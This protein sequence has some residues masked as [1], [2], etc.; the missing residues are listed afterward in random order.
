MFITDPVKSPRL[1][2]YPT[3]DKASAAV[4]MA[5]QA[6]LVRNKD[7][8]KEFVG[9]HRNME[10]VAPTD[11]KYKERTKLSPKESVDKELLLKI[12]KAKLPI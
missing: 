12:S 2:N 9:R 10:L 5:S 1:S 3:S 8:N 4:L 7:G 11:G 6:S